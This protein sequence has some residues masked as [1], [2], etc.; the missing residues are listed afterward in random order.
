MFFFCNVAGTLSWL[1]LAG[2]STSRRGGWGEG[3]GGG[4]AFELVLLLGSNS[5]R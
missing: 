3:G 5:R 4:D 1:S 2:S